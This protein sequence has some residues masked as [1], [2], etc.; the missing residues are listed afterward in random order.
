MAH[1]DIRDAYAALIKREDKTRRKLADTRE[2]LKTAREVDVTATAIAA[3]AGEPAPKR[4]ELTL[5]HAE[6]NL[7]VELDGIDEGVFR[8]QQAARA[9]VGEGHDFPIFIPPDIP[10]NRDAVI[11]TAMTDKN[12]QPDESEAEF[13]ARVVREIPRSEKDAETIVA[14]AHRQR[15]ISLDRRLPR[16][17]ER[18]TDLIA[19]IELAYDAEDE[20]AEDAYERKAK[21]QR[22]HEATEAAER[23]KREHRRRGLPAGSFSIHAYPDIVLPEHLAEFKQPINRSPFSIAREAEAGLPSYEE[24]QN[25]PVASPQPVNEAKEHREREIAGIPPA[26]APDVK[27]INPYADLPPEERAAARAAKIAGE[28]AA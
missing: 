21:K 26:A 9:A 11:A 13:E 17:T 5:R 7:S 23:A 24:A 15:E 22:L 4:T 16:L 8:L 14:E 2:K 25:E 27:P 12:R 18:P 6:E 28:E 3:L 10:A 19:W 20:K 1:D